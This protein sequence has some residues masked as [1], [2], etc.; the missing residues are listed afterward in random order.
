MSTLDA[1]KSRFA[2]RRLLVAVLC[3]LVVVTAA[4]RLPSALGD[5]LWLDEVASA[6][7]LAEPTLPAVLRHVRRTESTPPLWYVLS[8]SVRRAGSPWLSITGLRLLSVLLSCAL[9]VATVLYARRLLSLGWAAL[10]GAVVALGPDLVAHGSELRAY[11]LLALL[12]VCFA[13][14]L[15]SA[16]RRPTRLR[17]GALGATV[18]AG[19]L[20][21]YFF[22]LTLL[23][24]LAWLVRERNHAGSRVAAAA[25]GV[26]LIPLVAW[27]PAFY[28]QYE[29]KLYAFSGPFSLRDVLYPSTFHSDCACNPPQGIRCATA[30]SGVFILVLEGNAEGRDNGLCLFTPPGGNPV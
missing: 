17:M 23:A 24:G 6:R 15:E 29:H 10:A 18:A 3:A 16:A 20:T 28:R 13:Q 26:G 21:H 14:I 19:C 12:S 1:C 7:I 5:P 11:T 2:G 22:L 25:V 27:A 9:T 4:A 8:W 30:D